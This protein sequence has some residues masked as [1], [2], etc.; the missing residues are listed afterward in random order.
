VKRERG[1]ERMRREREKERDKGSERR[2]ERE[3]RWLSGDRSDWF[4]DFRKSYVST[5]V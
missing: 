2:R 3:T 1:S 5:I 4:V